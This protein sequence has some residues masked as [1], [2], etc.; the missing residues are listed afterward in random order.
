MVWKGFQRQ[1]QVKE[2]L[3]SRT[4]ELLT[5]VRAD[6]NWSDWDGVVFYFLSPGFSLGKFTV[7]T[8]S[9]NKP[10]PLLIDTTI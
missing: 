7:T 10:C 5:T 9:R 2:D 8:S 6:A 4:C 3:V 1:K